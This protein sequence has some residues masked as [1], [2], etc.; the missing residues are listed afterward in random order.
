[1]FKKKGLCMVR[2][3]LFLTLLTLL[4]SARENPFFPINSKEPLAVTTNIKEKI[5]KLTS[6]TVKLP[7]TARVLQKVTLT[8][9]NLDGSIAKKSIELNEAV[10]WHLP[11]F[12]TQ[13]Y[14]KKEQLKQAQPPKVNLNSRVKNTELTEHFTKVASLSFISFYAKKRSLKIVTKD[15]MKRDFMLVKPH[16]IVCDFV[17]ETDIGSYI[18]KIKGINSAFKKI[19][20]GTHNRYYRVVIELDGYYVYKKIKTKSG[21][22]LELH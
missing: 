7:S 8:Y 14:P 13:S 16:R 17:R 3:V 19:R 4:A 21:Y 11:I 22:I 15:I 20:I 5:S 12:I 9:K 6:A 2:A 18:R 10:D 1:M